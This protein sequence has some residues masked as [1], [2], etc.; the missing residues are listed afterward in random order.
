MV[1]SGKKFLDSF[2]Y[3]I[4]NEYTGFVDEPSILQFINETALGFVTE[5]TAV[6]EDVVHYLNPLRV[7]TDGKGYVGPLK[8][9]DSIL[10]LPVMK[11]SGTTTLT[12]HSDVPISYP[13][14][15]RLNYVGVTNT[16]EYGN[17]KKV[18]VTTKDMMPLLT[19]RHYRKPSDENERI[20]GYIMSE[21][22][23][24]T[25]MYITGQ[26]SYG[27]IDYFRYPDPIDN[28][29]D[30]TSYDSNLL[31]KIKNV[32]VA[33]FLERIKDER[34]RNFIQGQQ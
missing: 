27:V 34:F 6:K 5:L 12:T 25:E 3:D 15:L 14:M 33:R 23:S 1:N 18:T 26:W 13:N 7:I 2:L 19:K 20:Y 28:S 11:K 17:E 16:V 22:T 9:T 24:S 21:G 30:A 4:R 29:D 31:L 8:V 10:Y 32:V